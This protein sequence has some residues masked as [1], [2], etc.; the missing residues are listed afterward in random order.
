MKYHPVEAA[1]E[2]PLR[3]FKAKNSIN[4]LAKLLLNLFNKIIFSHTCSFDFLS[5]LK[6]QF[7]LLPVPQFGN[8]LKIS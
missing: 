2:N 3:N 5:D 8:H 4:F 6:R 1:D 7:N